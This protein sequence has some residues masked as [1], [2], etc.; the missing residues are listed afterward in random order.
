VVRTEGNTLVGARR[1][2]RLFMPLFY[3]VAFLAVLI[4]LLTCAFSGAPF[5]AA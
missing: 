2:G 1:L 3:D 5:L 4:K